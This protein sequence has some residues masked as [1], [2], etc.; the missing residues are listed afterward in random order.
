MAERLHSLKILSSKSF[1]RISNLK[2]LNNVHLASVLVQELSHD[3]KDRQKYNSLLTYLK[4]ENSDIYHEILVQSKFQSLLR[5]AL[6]EFNL[7]N[8]ARSLTIG[9]LK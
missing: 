4:K 7:E 6:Y 5:L 3:L 8:I 1:H 9:N 2:E